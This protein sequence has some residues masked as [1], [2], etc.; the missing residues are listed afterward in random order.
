[1]I[2]NIAS[3]YI[4]MRRDLDI[5]PISLQVGLFK[6]QKIEEVFKKNF[7]QEYFNSEEENERIH[8]VLDIPKGS[9]SLDFY[10]GS[11]SE[12]I[13]HHL[14]QN[15]LDG[16]EIPNHIKRHV[17]SIDSLL[18]P[19]VEG[20][21]KLYTGLLKS[22][23]HISAMEWNSTRP[24]KLI[25]I[26]SYISTTSDFN[27]APFFTR[28]D[29]ET[30]HHESDHHGIVHKGAIH[31][32]ELNFENGIHNAASVKKHS[33][34]KHENEVLLGRNH[35]FVLNPRPTLLENSD[36]VNPLYLW[37]AHSFIHPKKN[38]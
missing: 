8:E 6:N 32:L 5:R 24:N 11:G 16:S 27:V 7:S 22:P 30:E 28:P 34:A 33:G 9:H 19:K 14:W 20:K 25:H 13:N 35:H 2:D 4:S 26:P 23:T 1:M 3:A 18:I 37:K 15:H 21:F 12:E 36:Y 31:V 29:E 38:K 10:T 17:A